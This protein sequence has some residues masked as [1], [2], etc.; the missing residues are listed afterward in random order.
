MKKQ[1]LRNVIIHRVA[2]QRMQKL[3]AVKV[4]VESEVIQV[5]LDAIIGKL[6]LIQWNAD[7]ADER[8]IIEALKAFQ[9]SKP[10]YTLDRYTAFQHVMQTFITTPRFASDT[11]NEAMHI[12]KLVNHLNHVIDMDKTRKQFNS[13]LVQDHRRRH[14]SGTVELETI[15]NERMELNQLLSKQKTSLLNELVKL[16]TLQNNFDKLNSQIKYFHLNQTL[17]P[18]AKFLITAEK[19]ATAALIDAQKN[20]ITAIK[21][22]IASLQVDKKDL[23]KTHK[24]LI[25]CIQNKRLTAEDAEFLQNLA[26]FLGVQL[27]EGYPFTN[28]GLKREVIIIKQRLR[29]IAETKDIEALQAAILDTTPGEETTLQTDERRDSVDFAC[30]TNNSPADTEGSFDAFNEGIGALHNVPIDTPMGA[31]DE[32]ED[33]NENET[34]I[35]D[36]KVLVIDDIDP[37]V[38][39]ARTPKILLVQNKNPQAFFTTDDELESDSF[40]DRHK[41]IL[42]ATALGLVAGLLVAAFFPP[43]VPFVVAL[44][45]SPLSSTLA[46]VAAVATVAAVTTAAS[47]LSGFIVSSIAA[48]F[49]KKPVV[50]A[51]IPQDGRIM[52]DTFDDNIATETTLGTPNKNNQSGS[53]LNVIE[54]LGK[55]SQSDISIATT[56]SVSS[57]TDSEEGNQWKP[58][59]LSELNKTDKRILTIHTDFS[60]A[61]FNQNKNRIKY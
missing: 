7:A 29:E 34:D 2:I 28:D 30:H 53:T 59:K 42:V 40:L 46:P 45:F 27:P 12:T 58:Y 37:A 52:D 43:V 25:E 48:T 16:G 8:L 55:A 14:G 17:S 56:N 54:K 18:Q 61:D 6:A 9:K 10:L 26:K 24:Q 33:E 57:N 38:L 23:L 15:K 11:S 41:I 35:P 1:R 60:T 4:G 51:V 32:N 36:P 3:A 47:A 44:I 13:G 31:T 50:G 20:S 49:R 19:D 39:P 22:T 5:I 21:E